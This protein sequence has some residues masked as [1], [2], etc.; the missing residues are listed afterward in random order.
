MIDEK[1]GQPDP[2]HPAVQRLAQLHPDDLHEIA[3][4]VHDLGHAL[5][6]AANTP[7]SGAH[8]QGLAGGMPPWMAT[9]FRQLQQLGPLARQILEMIAQYRVEQVQVGGQPVGTSTSAAQPQPAA[10]RPEGRPSA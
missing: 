7:Q 10:S 1:T 2:D 8:A 9:L 5:R 3:D 4:T 6:T